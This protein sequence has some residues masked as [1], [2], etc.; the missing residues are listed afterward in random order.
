MSSFKV[1]NWVVVYYNVLRKFTR[2]IFKSL[3]KQVSRAVL[4]RVMPYLRNLKKNP[5]WLIKSFFIGK[6]QGQL[7]H[8]CRFWTCYKVHVKILVI[9]H[10]FSEHAS[11]PISEFGEFSEHSYRRVES[12][13]L[14]GVCHIPQ[15][16]SSTYL[17]LV[18][19]T[20]Q[21]YSTALL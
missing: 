2:H 12:K 9:R 11:N 16:R 21:D 17:W 18:S 19:A 7:K 6:E 1:T 3:K 14:V 15:R 10:I 20:L 13:P 4:A 5:S 8:W